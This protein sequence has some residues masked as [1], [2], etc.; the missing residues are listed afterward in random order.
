MRTIKELWYNIKAI[1]ISIKNWYIKNDVEDNTVEFKHYHI[2]Y[3]KLDS[4]I[5]WF[6]DNDSENL[7]HIKS[8][9]FLYK[10]TKD[11]KLARFLNETIWGIEK[12]TN[13]KL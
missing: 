6:S 8:I 9:V 4:L 11:K 3:S 10:Q 2:K 5:K 13:I 7:N 12:N 1:Y